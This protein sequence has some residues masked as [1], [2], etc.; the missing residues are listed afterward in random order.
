MKRQR[1][2]KGIIIT[3]FLLFPAIFAYLSPYLIIQGAF[4]GVAVGSMVVFALMFLF[5]LFI[6]RAFCG[7]VCPA[8]AMQDC[9]AL[10]V[11][12]KPK[13]KWRNLMKYFIWV[14]WLGFIIA[15]AVSAGGLK[16]VDFFY[17]TGHG[18]SVSDFHSIIIYLVIIAIIATVALIAGKRSMCHYFCWMAPFMVI[19]TKIKDALGIP[20]LHLE[21]DPAKCSNCKQC[22]KKCAMSLDVQE[23]VKKGD[24]RNSECIL[25]GECADV[26]PRGAICFRLNGRAAATLTS[27]QSER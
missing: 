6:G 5:S 8:G 21:A 17:W 16:K 7:W 27:E 4:E 12:K 9:L 22:S 24:M 25:C 26:C 23:M 2:R 19:G 3:L 14:P 1:I 18:I 20:S 15:G 10:A 13:G 11:D